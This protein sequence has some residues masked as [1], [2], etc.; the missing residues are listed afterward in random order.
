MPKRI[1]ILLLYILYCFNGISQ[2]FVWAKSMGGSAQ[3][4]YGNS[5]ITDSAGNIYTTGRFFGIVDFDPSG[6]VYNLTSTGDFDIFIS[7]LS[8]AGDRTV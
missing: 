8:P 2:N 3:Y 5:I 4:D 1:L 7:K 6:N